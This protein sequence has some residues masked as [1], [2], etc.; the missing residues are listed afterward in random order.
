MERPIGTITVRSGGTQIEIHNTANTEPAAAG[1]RPRAL[2]LTRSQKRLALAGVVALSLIASVVWWAFGLGS[3][4][5]L[6]PILSLL[7]IVIG[8]RAL[9]RQPLEDPANADDLA[10]TRGLRV[11]AVLSTSDEPLTVEGLAVRLSWTEDAVVG[12][13]KQLQQEGRLVEDL[14]LDT[15]HWNYRLTTEDDDIAVPRRAL[16]LSERATELAT[17]LVEVEEQ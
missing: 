9:G 4:A 1:A 5:L 14:D 2:S 15:G 12:G 16:P 13:L 10:R 3:W 11:A 7:A 6:P 17:A 8:S